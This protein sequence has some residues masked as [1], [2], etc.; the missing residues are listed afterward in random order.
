M[1]EPGLESESELEVI[2][3]PCPKRKSLYGLA[4]FHHGQKGGLLQVAGLDHSV[5]LEPRY[6]DGVLALTIYAVVT[7]F[8]TGLSWGPGSPHL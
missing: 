6:Q 8:R 1:A 2:L 3:I 4:A 7:L 5:H